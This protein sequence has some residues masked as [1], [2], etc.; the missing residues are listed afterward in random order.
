MALP[1]AS[2]AQTSSP[3]VAAPQAAP[4]VSPDDKPVPPSGK[5]LQ[6]EPAKAPAPKAAAQPKVAPPVLVSETQSP[7]PATPKVAPK[8]MKL[9]PA[10]GPKAGTLTGK[11][12]LKRVGSRLGGIVRSDLFRTGAKGA[13]VAVVLLALQLLLALD[14]QRAGGR[15]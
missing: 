7:A 2:A 4:K 5:V 10:A 12:A 13:L 8:A 15:R 1:V 14:R 11:L 3:V 6:V 9:E